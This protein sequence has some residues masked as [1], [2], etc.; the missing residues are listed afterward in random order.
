M[1]KLLL[2]IF[3][4]FGCLLVLTNTSEIDKDDD[5]EYVDKRENNNDNDEETFRNADEDGDDDDEVD[6][7]ISDDDNIVDPL[8]K[9]FLK[10]PVIAKDDDNDNEDDYILRDNFEETTYRLKANPCFA[11]INVSFRI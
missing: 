1:R 3:C 10:Y 11:R 6:D 4:C 9:N 8:I 7:A 2:N 5:L